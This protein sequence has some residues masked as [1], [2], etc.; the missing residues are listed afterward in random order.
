MWEGKSTPISSNISSIPI[1]RNNLFFVGCISSKNKNKGNKRVC[2]CA[3]LSDNNP[4]ANQ[5]RVDMRTAPKCYV[6][7]WKVTNSTAYS[8]LPRKYHWAQ[9]SVRLCLFMLIC[10][11]TCCMSSTLILTRYTGKS[12]LLFSLQVMLPA[13]PPGRPSDP[14]FVLACGGWRGDHVAKSNIFATY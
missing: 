9:F 6:T 13:K 7:C 8:N 10:W 2:Q 5:A 1:Y 4:R 11:S 3:S 14:R 12:S